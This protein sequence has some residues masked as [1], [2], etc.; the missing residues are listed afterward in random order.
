[1]K[2][3]PLFLL[4]GGVAA[5]AALFFAKR[6]SDATTDAITRAVSGTASLSEGDVVVQSPNGAKGA[7]VSLRLTGYWPFSATAA[8]L[9]MEG[10]VNDRKG[11]PLHTVEDYLAGKA[12][13]VSLSGDDAIFPYGQR[14]D[15]PWG[16]R[17]LIGR[18][19]DTG[20]HFR[21]AG[22]LYRVA[23]SEPIDVCVAT[24]KTVI[25]QKTVT[26]AIIS[27]DNLAGGKAVATGKFTG[28]TVTAG[29]EIGPVFGM[30]LG[31]EDLK[32]I[33][34]AYNE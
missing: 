16:S 34:R 13:H 2:K 17:T 28:Q 14:I 19:T 6:K 25:P 8:E 1:M 30:V 7:Q 31:D 20:S 11:K 22:K 3:A 5:I 26:A 32:W 18:V 9:K 15:I 23:G 12:D 27:G 33:G 10:G 29:N 21:G 24:S 4:G